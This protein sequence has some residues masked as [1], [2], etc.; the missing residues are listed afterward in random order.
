MLTEKEILNVG[1]K[2]KERLWRYRKSD[3]WRLSL[4][5]LSAR[6]RLNGLGRLIGGYR[7]SMS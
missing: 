3:A 7:G 1:L 4:N 2:L 6:R 5:I